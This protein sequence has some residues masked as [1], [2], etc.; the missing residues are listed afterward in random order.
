MCLRHQG[1][2]KRPGTAQPETARGIADCF[3]CLNMLLV[4]CCLRFPTQWA[5]REGSR[6]ATDGSLPPSS[7]QQADFCESLFGLCLVLSPKQ[8]ASGSCLPRKNITDRTHRHG[9]C[10][11]PL[12]AVRSDTLHLEPRTEARVPT[13]PRETIYKQSCVVFVGECNRL[14]GDVFSRNVH[15]CY[16][17]GAFSVQASPAVD[18][19]T[20]KLHAPRFRSLTKEI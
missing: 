15:R 2:R 3:F 8:H 18:G 19:S 12:F 9:S 1:Q 5:S 6:A 10:R 14:G 20:K 7:N 16:C 4:L 11:Y 17:S 13:C